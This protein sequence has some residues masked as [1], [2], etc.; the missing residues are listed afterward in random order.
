[1]LNIFAMSTQIVVDLTCLVGLLS[2]RVLSFLKFFVD[3]I[4]GFDGER[5]CQKYSALYLIC[6]EAYA[7]GADNHQ[8]TLTELSLMKI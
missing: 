1:M 4:P 8:N 5:L 6:E 3:P 7:F 2:Q